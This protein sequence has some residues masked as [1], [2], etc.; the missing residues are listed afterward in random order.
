MQCLPSYAEISSQIVEKV[1]RSEGDVK[2]AK[3]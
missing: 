3:F 1:W 2:V